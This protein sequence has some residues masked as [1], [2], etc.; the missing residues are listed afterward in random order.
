PFES[1]PRKV[2][3]TWRIGRADRID[4]GMETEKAPDER[5]IISRSGIRREWSGNRKGNSEIRAG[6]N[7]IN[8][9]MPYRRST[10][11]LYHFYTRQPLAARRRQQ[12]REDVHGRRCSQCNQ[13][14]NP[15]ARGKRDV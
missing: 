6:Q 11:L 8:G 9:R 10:V 3:W 5:V 2:L 14:Q 4:Q 7:T 12:Q 15:A 1:D 13:N